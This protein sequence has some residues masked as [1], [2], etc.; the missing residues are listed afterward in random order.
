[1]YSYLNASSKEMNAKIIQW[2]SGMRGV[3]GAS[4]ALASPS[5]VMSLRGNSSAVGLDS[6][7]E[8][9]SPQMALLTE[10]MLHTILV[11]HQKFSYSKLSNE[12]I[13]KLIADCRIDSNITASLLRRAFGIAISEAEVTRTMNAGNVGDPQIDFATSASTGGQSVGS[14]RARPSAKFP[15][16]VANNENIPS[17]NV[18]APTTLMESSNAIDPKALFKKVMALR[19]PHI[20]PNFGTLHQPYDGRRYRFVLLF[21]SISYHNIYCSNVAVPLRNRLTLHNL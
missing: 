10:Q 19:I 16:Q 12:S 18:E 7:F 4:S 8:V 14:Y 13:K 15:S 3:G 1:M 17:S 11:P 6:L 21:V 20:S 5:R 2:R 9:M